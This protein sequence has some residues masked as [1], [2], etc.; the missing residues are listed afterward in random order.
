MRRR[1][2]AAPSPKALVALAKERDQA[3]LV[4]REVGDLAATFESDRDLRDLFARPRITA[5]VTRAVAMEVAQRSGLSKLTGDFVTLVAGRGRTDHLAAIAEK[6]RQ[7]RDED[8]GRVRARV[9]TAVPLT[10]EEGGMLD[11]E[12]TSFLDSVRS[13]FAHP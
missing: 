1:R 9:R 11:A 13:T 10:G 6:Y 3:E 5:T 7:L 2:A 8:L 4:A 12:D